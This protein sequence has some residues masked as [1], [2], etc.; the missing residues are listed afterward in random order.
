MASTAKG[1]SKSVVV[2][3]AASGAIDPIDLFG[4]SLDQF[5]GYWLFNTGPNAIW[6]Y[7]NGEVATA[8]GDDSILLPVNQWMYVPRPKAQPT[9]AAAPN[10]FAATIPWTAIAVTANSTLF[11]MP[12]RGGMVHPA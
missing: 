9:G 2:A 8:G 4:F 7:Q 1:I 3:F 12:D 5:G 11:I 6:L 10:S